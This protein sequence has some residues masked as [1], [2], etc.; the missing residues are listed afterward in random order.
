MW[1]TEWVA[2][3]LRR[4]HPEIVVEV[5]PIQT[6]G[7][8]DKAT[9]LAGMGQV[10]VFTKEIE[11]ALLDGRCDVGVHS[12]KDLATKLP[13]G[14]LLGAVPARVDP[15][16]A[17]VSRAGLTLADLPAGSLVGSSSLRRR[18]MVLHHRPDLRITE[19]RGN[20]PTRLRSVGVDIDEGKEP[21]DEL[22]DATVMALSGLKRLGL[23]GHA[24]EILPTERFLPAPAQGALAI[25][26]RGG[27][28]RAVEL[29]AVLDHRP[30]RRATAAE[31]TFLAL[32]EGG[33]HVPLGALASAEGDDVRLEGVVV[34]LDGS[35][36][37][38][39]AA[40]GSDPQAVGTELA[41]QLKLKGAED[42]LARV[43]VA[44]EP[45]E[46]SA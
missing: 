38:R 27:D 19:L 4:Q 42:I 15:R 13:E 41:E 33:C 36:A 31:R 21:T 44:L 30:T 39:G 40:L 45:R 3:E 25:E 5:V 24:T 22:L 23:D 46:G 12:Y 6:L 14:L 26:C 35:S 2:A 43:A 8:R 17:L 1:Q 32:M 16:D 7:D 37:V 28:R 18:A 34:D 20:V 11:D 10:G 9:S 29:L